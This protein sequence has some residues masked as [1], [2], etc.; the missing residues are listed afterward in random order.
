[1]LRKVFKYE[2]RALGRFLLPFFGFCIAGAGLLRVLMWLAPIIWKPAADIIIAV[3][4]TFSVLLVMAL[5][6]ITVIIILARFYQ[7]MLTSEGYLNFTLPVTLHSHLL[8]RLLS[9][10]IFGV[11]GVFITYFAGRIISWQPEQNFLLLPPAH[12]MMNGVA[13]NIPASLYA[14]LLLLLSLFAITSIT[15]SILKV[16][17][18]M[19]L[20]SQLNKNRILG[21]ILF[22]MGLNMAEGFIVMPLMM[23]SMVKMFGNNFSYFETLNNGNINSPIEI[24]QTINQVLWMIL[25]VVMVLFI[26]TSVAYYFISHFIFSK[27][28]NL[29]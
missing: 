28:L 26:L 11:A 19:A 4:S 21:S 12:I 3:S 22:Y 5:L 24:L 2:M 14:S 6:L 18:A 29:E 16:Y 25:G 9:G 27:K 15:V 20:G 13:H 8:G 23:F 1:M 17:T 10:V 7:S